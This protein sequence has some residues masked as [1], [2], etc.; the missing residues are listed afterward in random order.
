[1]KGLIGKARA[2]LV[3]SS[4]IEGGD[5]GGAASGLG[6]LSHGVSGPT[7]DPH[8]F[9]RPPEIQPPPTYME[10]GDRA[11]G[12]FET[13]PN[14]APTVA[15]R[16][17]SEHRAGSGGDFTAVHGVGMA[18]AMEAASAAPPPTTGVESRRR[19]SQG[20]GGTVSGGSTSANGS[21]GSSGSTMTMG[22][23]SGTGSSGSMSSHGFGKVGSKA[24]KP[25]SYDGGD[26]CC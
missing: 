26:N 23:S 21:S 6:G 2:K 19:H 22:S 1:M 20:G 7:A 9:M 4:T 5:M 24:Q 16:G 8:N 18:R 25:S 3:K 17:Y 11:G 13:L 14:M 10:G 12:D 15:K